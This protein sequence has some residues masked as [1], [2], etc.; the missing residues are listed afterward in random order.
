MTETKL[1]KPRAILAF[2]K[3]FKVEADCWGDVFFL[4]IASSWPDFFRSAFCFVNDAGF[5][6]KNR[7]KVKGH[8]VSSR[9]VTFEGS[10]SLCHIWGS[11]CML[12]QGRLKTPF[13]DRL[14]TDLSDGI[15]LLSPVG[16]DTHD[17][18]G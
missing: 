17:F 7:F 9:G 12:G 18:D 15:Y 14:T 6:E 8:Q 4:R 3:R 13:P 5:Q 10:L 16:S 11:D 2:E 1:D